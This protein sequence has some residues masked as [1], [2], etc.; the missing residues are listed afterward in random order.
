ML[1]VDHPKGPNPVF[2]V[3][4]G[5][6]IGKINFLLVFWCFPLILGSNMVI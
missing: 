4:G 2:P 6:E 5:L 1:G 3:I